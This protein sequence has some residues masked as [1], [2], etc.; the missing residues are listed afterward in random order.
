MSDI[1]QQMLDDIAI[2][3]T[4][5]KQ[6]WYNGH[7]KNIVEEAYDRLTD[8]GN[9]LITREHAK[10]EVATAEDRLTAQKF[11]LDAVSADEIVYG[12]GKQPEDGCQE[13][14]KPV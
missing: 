3:I 4:G 5:K 2:V 9:K 14:D 1:Q 13:V 6:R 11:L 8:Y 12:S 10:R 7:R